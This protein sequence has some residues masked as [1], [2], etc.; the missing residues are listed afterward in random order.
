MTLD[1]SSNSLADING[2]LTS[3]PRLTRLDVSSNALQWFDYAFVPAS[4]RW[5]SLA[6]NSI[7]SLENYYNIGE[8]FKL[9]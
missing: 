2:L 9:E 3:H 7:D 6:G 1:L 4:V 5:L 8:N